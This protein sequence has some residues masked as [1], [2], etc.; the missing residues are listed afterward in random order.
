MRHTHGVTVGI[1]LPTHTRARFLSSLD[2]GILRAT[3]FDYVGIVQG[4]MQRSGPGP[5]YLCS[6][7]QERCRMLARN[8]KCQ[9]GTPINGNLSPSSR[10]KGSL[11]MCSHCGDFMARPGELFQ[12]AAKACVPSFTR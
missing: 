3:A 11:Y 7:V 9:Y 1:K 4:G 8:I 10:T 5:L 6:T 12:W 2:G